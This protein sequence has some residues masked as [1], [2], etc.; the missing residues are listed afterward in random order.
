L[1]ANPR[2]ILRQF[3]ESYFWGTIYEAVTSGGENYTRDD[4]KLSIKL[5]NLI[6]ASPDR[7]SDKDC[8]DAAVLLEKVNGGS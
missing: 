4:M 8:A 6:E 3:P 2:K 5:F 1:S 7:I